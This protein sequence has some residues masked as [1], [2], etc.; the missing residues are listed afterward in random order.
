M[1]GDRV[2]N[3]ML[4]SDCPVGVQIK[5]KNGKKDTYYPAVRTGWKDEAKLILNTISKACGVN[6]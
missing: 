3:A 6:H 4:C 5:L 1:V 2:N